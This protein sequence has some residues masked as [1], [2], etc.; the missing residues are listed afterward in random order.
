MAD[1]KVEFARR[2]FEALPH[3][4]ALGLEIVSIDDGVIEAVLPYREEL[5][6]DPATG[7]IA[8]GAVSTLMDTCGGAAVMT[9]PDG[10]PGTATLDLRIDSMRA[11]T[12]GQAVRARATCYHM[13]RRVAF[14]RATAWDDD[15]RPIATAAGAFTV[16]R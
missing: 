3:A 11:A 12:P 5:I 4:R 13:T 15:E 10:V 6:G 2:F 8:G 16:D 9:H 1:G 7:V 14:V